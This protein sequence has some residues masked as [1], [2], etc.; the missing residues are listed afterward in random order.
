MNDFDL[1]EN[2]TSSS[3]LNLIKEED[4]KKTKVAFI[5]IALM[6]VVLVIGIVLSYLAPVNKKQVVYF[7]IEDGQSLGDISQN[8]DDKNVIKNSSVFSLYARFTGSPDSYKAGE[9]VIE[10]PI[11]L[12]AL[13]AMFVNGGKDKVVSPSL[14]ISYGFGVDNP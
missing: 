7:S 2:E 14:T 9:Y 5:I 8:L 12:K 13:D 6:I 11:S 3:D 4:K 10:T 1:Q